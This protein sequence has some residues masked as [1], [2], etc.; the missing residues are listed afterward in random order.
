MQ[1]KHSLTN[2]EGQKPLYPPHV[3]QPQLWSGLLALP[4]TQGGFC[5][6]KIQ[7]RAVHPQDVQNLQSS[8]G[9][10]RRRGH[11]SCTELTGTCTRVSW[12]Q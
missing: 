8:R 7:T 2:L 11:K 10:R 6:A 1:T 12:L 3:L 4:T 9:R 5:S